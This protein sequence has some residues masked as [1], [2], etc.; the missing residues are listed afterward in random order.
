MFS[1]KNQSPS[2]LKVYPMCD[3]MILYGF[4][5]CV[6]FDCT[7]D[8]PLPDPT[9]RLK[10]WPAVPGHVSLPPVLLYADDVPL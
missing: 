8:V 1:Q 2:L 3:R 9:L 10:L 7:M 5:S 4:C 6:L